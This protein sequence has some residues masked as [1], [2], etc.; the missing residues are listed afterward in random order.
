MEATTQVTRPQP[1][2]GTLVHFE[3]P[4]TDPAKI[5][6]FY[7][8]LFGWK[9]NKWE[10]GSMDYWLI[11]HKDATSPDDTIGGLFKRNNPQ[12]QFLN[13]VLV[14]SVDD[15]VAKATGLG[16]KVL[17]AKQEIPNMGW[18]AVLADPDGNTFALYQSKSGM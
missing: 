11:S 18:F 5:S 6:S 12:E 16:A 13:Y 10:G 1:K 3:I 8:Q 7:S 2:E 17:M 9:F 14:K 4:A 15:S